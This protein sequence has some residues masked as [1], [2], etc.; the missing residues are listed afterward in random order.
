MLRLL[1]LLL[2]TWTGSA[3]VR[4][5]LRRVP[6]IRAQLRTQGL[7]EEFLKDHRPDMFNRRYAQCFP[8][9]TPSLRLRRS[10]EKIYNFMDAQYYGEIS[11]GTP[12]QNFSVIF[13]TGSADLWVPSSYCVSQACALHR[14][15]KAFESKTFHHDG[16]IFGIHYGSGHLLGVMGRDTVK[17]GEMTI[18]NQQFGESVYEPDSAFVSAKF[19]G[20]LGLAYQS[21]AEIQGN[22]VFDN[23]LAQ[24]IVDQPVFSF[25]L[26]RRTRT[27]TPE[28][29]LLLGGID[30]AMYNRPIN[31]L[32]VTAKG[33]WQIKMES[34]TVQGV[35]S[36]CP[37]GCHAI[38]DT[39]TSLIGGPTTEILRL[40]QL[41]GATPTNNGEFLIDCARLS[42]LPHVTFIMGG[43]EYTLTS[44]QY[45]RKEGFGSGDLCFS[46]FQSIDIISPEGPLWILGDVFLTEYYS[47]FDR[48][49]DR[50]GLARAK[51]PTE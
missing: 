45:V 29:E 17:I 49:L 25:Y 42:S 41:I 1:L 24:N 10:S 44:E 48:G 35:S 23:M 30:E 15:F 32:P 7:L 28:G 4:V 22:P 40:Q 20:V 47:I 3:M 18:L 13:D 37:R 9:G 33:Y 43:K 46:G 27:S 34:V 16:R 36:F 51:H 14:R 19:D 8:P 50:I 2:S 5:P 11:V 6:S 26:S 21:L 12:P 38:V 39:G 31:W